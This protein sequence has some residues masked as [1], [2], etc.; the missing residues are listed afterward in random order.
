M[1]DILLT[2]DVDTRPATTSLQG[3]GKVL[4]GAAILG[5]FKAIIDTSVEFDSS[6]RQ[7]AAVTRASADD[8]AAFSEQAKELG[9]TTQFTASQVAD[10]QAFLGRAG[11]ETNEILTATPGLL[12]L[13]AAG[14]LGLG[15]A[16]DIASNVVQA[17]NL[18]AGETGRVADVL[19]EA[20]QAQTQM[21][22]S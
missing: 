7:V 21:S 16:A 5:G 19:A 15:E 9:T 3:L 20:A 2:A 13:A 1:A 4:S 11:F 8:M 17:F 6:I 10:A 14:M 12:D 18:G 22:N